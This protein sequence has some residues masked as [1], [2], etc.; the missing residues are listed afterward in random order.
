MNGAAKDAALCGLLCAAAAAV[1]SLGG[2]IPAS[3]FCC[4]V[5]ASVSLVLA[6]P[7]V[8]ARLLWAM[9][10]AIAV[11]SLLLSPDKEAAAIFLALGYYPIIRPALERKKPLV[12]WCVKLALFYT[13]IAL[14][15]ALL[16][17]VLRPAALVEEFDAMGRTLAA[18]L[19]I[20]GGTVFVLYD[21]ALRALERRLQTRQKGRI[22]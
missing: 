9:Y 11:L 1:M 10:A 13:A 18:A 15:Y 6:R 2:L 7:R 8:P 5:L 21:L 17:F 14:V 19:L 4:P 3:T 20:L 22:R 16:L 12:R